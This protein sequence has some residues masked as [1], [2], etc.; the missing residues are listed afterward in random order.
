MEGDVVTFQEI[1]QNVHFYPRPPGGGR[2]LSIQYSGLSRSISIHALRVEGDEAEAAAP[3]RGKI[4]IHALR[5]EGDVV[6]FQEIIQNVHFYPRPP[7]GGR[8]LSIQYSGLS[9]SIS[10]HALRVEGDWKEG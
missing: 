5:V 9:R 3:T 10:I 7:G 8:L 4:S 6:T 1:I 2:L